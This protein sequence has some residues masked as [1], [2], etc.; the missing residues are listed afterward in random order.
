MQKSGV[1]F[2]LAWFLFAAVVLVFA[3]EKD[4]PHHLGKAG[5]WEVTNSTTWQKTPVAPGTPG[6]PPR[7]TPRTVEVCLTQE[8]VDAGALLPQS[9][10]QCRIEDKVIKPGSLVANYVCS[11]KMQ[12]TGKLETTLPDP[13]HVKGSIHFE[14]TMD[15]QG[16][17]RPIEWTTISNAVFKGADCSQNPAQP[18][19]GASK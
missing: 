13:E 3:Q 16:H 11:G 8:M 17:S 7:G 5:L 12:G 14:G 4:A 19:P 6:G 9:R 18:A 10:G 1:G 2:G 15:V